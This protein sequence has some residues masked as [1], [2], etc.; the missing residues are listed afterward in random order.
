MLY[1]L[2]FSFRLSV[3]FYWVLFWFLLVLCWYFLWQNGKYTTHVL[4][5]NNTALITYINFGGMDELEAEQAHS[6][7][8]N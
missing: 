7:V 2:T 3:C 8:L 1:S 4:P 5:L 6:E